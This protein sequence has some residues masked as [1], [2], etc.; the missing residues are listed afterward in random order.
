[1]LLEEVS[2]SG[3]LDLQIT[4]CHSEAQTKVDGGPGAFVCLCLIAICWFLF[5]EKCHPSCFTCTGGFYLKCLK[6]PGCSSLIST[7]CP[8]SSQQTG[9]KKKKVFFIQGTFHHCVCRAEKGV[10]FSWR[11][12]FRA[13]FVWFQK[14]ICIS[15]CENV[16]F[17]FPAPDIL[18]QTLLRR[19][20]GPYVSLVAHLHC[21]ASQV[22]QLGQRLEQC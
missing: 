22:Q 17:L 21:V 16:C 8:M 1:M 4:V 3:V 15:I 5:R 12:H 6:P 7:W 13:R 14:S 11:S 9:Q 19:K 18:P 2:D 20:S 10:R